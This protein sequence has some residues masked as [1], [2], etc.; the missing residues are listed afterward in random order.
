MGNSQQTPKGQKARKKV[1]PMSGEYFSKSFALFKS[2]ESLWSTGAKDEM[3]WHH[4][5]QFDM[6]KSTIEASKIPRDGARIMS[7]GAGDGKTDIALF[8][9]LGLKKV[10]YYACE[11]N[12]ELRA[13]L[14]Q[15]IAG[16]PDGLIAKI[17]VDSRPQAIGVEPEGDE[18]F[19]AIFI[20]HAIY[21]FH[22][23]T[24]YL[25]WLATT[26]LKNDGSIFVTLHGEGLF[27]SITQKYRDV[28]D[29]TFTDEGICYEKV[30]EEMKLFPNIAIGSSVCKK[31]HHLAD[32]FLATKQ[33]N[34]EEA[35][36]LLSFILGGDVRT[37]PKEMK[38]DMYAY[39]RSLVTTDSG[40]YVLANPDCCIVVKRSNPDIVA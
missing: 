27:T 14:R 3:G 15:T 35:D 17:D 28:A 20:L 38:E 6:L 4:Q 16:A 29:Q 40:K 26:A 36:M 32:V 13:Q 37:L 22:E 19:D 7:M 8:Q 10:H 39:G 30:V 11:P 23:P 12:A 2:K 24:K 18:K 1:T 21:H 5:S 9:E 34:T 31:G 33:G 25:D